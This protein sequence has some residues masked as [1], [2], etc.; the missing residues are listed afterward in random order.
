M[1][2]LV[3]LVGPKG[4][5]KTRIAAMLAD[6]FGAHA[7]PVEAMWLDRLARAPRGHGEA[8]RTWEREGFDAVIDHALGALDESEVVVLDTTATSEHTPHLLARLASS[9]ALVVVRV[10]AT[11]ARCTARA[12]ARDAAGQIPTSPERLAAINE[13]AGRVSLAFDASFD[14]EGPWRELEARAWWHDLLVSRGADVAA[15]V[16]T[17]ETPRLLL[18][19]WLDADLAPFAAL[20]ADPAVMEHFERPLGEP[21]SDALAGRIRRELAR[22]GAGLWAVERHDV[23]SPCFVGFCGLSVPTFE[24]PFLP[25]VEVGWRLARSAWGRGLATEAARTVIAHGFAIGLPEI[26][27]FTSPHNTRSLRVMEKLGMTRDPDGD[28]EHPRVSVGHLLRP[29]VLYRLAAAR[30][31]V[32]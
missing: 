5:G 2:T 3:L 12:L 32:D 14:N 21:E 9:G 10:A 23:D 28:F 30:V 8:A 24:A 7:V 1:R 13:L 27:S 11:P 16:P 17:L 26:V 20:N 29:H 18:R 31:A 19:A 22:R 6:V 25:A 15:R 4:A